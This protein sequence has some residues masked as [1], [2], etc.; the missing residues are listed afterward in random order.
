MSSQ[1]FH[2]LIDTP[3][4]VPEVSQSIS[5][6]IQSPINVPHLSISSLIE[7]PLP[8]HPGKV[9]AG[10]IASP[11]FNLPA[12]KSKKRI[13]SWPSKHPK[14]AKKIHVATLKQG[15]EASPSYDGFGMG[16]DD[17]G[18]GFLSPNEDYKM[19][20]VIDWSI[21]S[22]EV[23]DLKVKIVPMYWEK[24]QTVVHAIVRV[25]SRLYILQ[26]WNRFGYLMVCKL[27]YLFNQCRSTSTSTFTEW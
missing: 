15:I 4:K 25:T 6:L 10:L 14:R 22:H 16:F 8:T 5:N 7:S 1:N 17:D 9:P 19:E 18:Q 20:D 24:L 21:T 26:D 2:G 13:R 23:I 27:L 3:I 11:I 12:A